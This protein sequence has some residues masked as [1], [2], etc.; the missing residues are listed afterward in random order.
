MFLLGSWEHAG[1][2]TCP[3]VTIF[4]LVSCDVDAD[5]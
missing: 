2:E 1:M 4:K 5:T 3:A